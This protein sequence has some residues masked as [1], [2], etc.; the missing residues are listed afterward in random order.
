MALVNAQACRSL[1]IPSVSNNEVA[2]TP[3]TQAEV[4]ARPAT[5]IHCSAPNYTFGTT[6]TERPWNARRMEVHSRARTMPGPDHYNL[7]RD[8]PPAERTS[9]KAGGGRVLVVSASGMNSMTDRFRIRPCGVNAGITRDG[10]YLKVPSEL[11]YVPPSHAE[12]GSKP[13]T[14]IQW[15]APQYSFGTARD[16]VP[17]PGDMANQAPW[18]HAS[19]AA[20]GGE[21]PGP[22]NAHISLYRFGDRR[23]TQSLYS[24][25]TSTIVDGRLRTTQASAAFPRKQIL[26]G[27]HIGS[28]SKTA[29]RPAVFS[30]GLSDNKMPSNLAV[31]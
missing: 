31:S 22:S 10:G 26:A 16:K 14:S 24:A 12:V 15:G 25:S 30:Y 8:V 13:P 5:S 11:A 17:L 6:A 23:R 20:P 2:Y 18:M 7:P 19:L 3:A 1:Y 9:V 21:S 27:A 4:G 28:D 29:S